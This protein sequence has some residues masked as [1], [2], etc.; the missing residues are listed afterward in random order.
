MICSICGD[1]EAVVFMRHSAKATRG[2]LALCEECAAL[3]GLTVGKG[4]LELRFEDLLAEVPPN[5]S[6]P[7]ARCPH[8]GSDLDLVRREARI[9]CP[10]CA[11]VFRPE[12]ERYMRT[13]SRPPYHRVSPEPLPPSMEGPRPELLS[14]LGRALAEEDYEAAA[15]IRDGLAQIAHPGQ[16]SPGPSGT[17]GL[18][19][20]ALGREVR[21]E[22]LLSILAP[23]IPQ[24]PQAAPPP[25]EA[26][27]ADVILDTRALRSRN[28]SGELFP[29]RAGQGGPLSQG[30]A[31]RLEE[32]SASLPGYAL[33]EVCGLGREFMPALAELAL[34]PRRASLDSRTPLL[35][36]PARDSY[37]LFCQDSHIEA[38]TRLR[39]LA[40]TASLSLLRAA[41]E[42]FSSF[43]PFAF[44]EDFG[45]LAPRL[46]DCGTGLCL[47][48]LVHLPALA[49]EGLVEKALRGLLSRGL[50]VKGFYGSEEGSLGDLWLVG[51]EWAFGAS[52]Q[53][54]ASEF[55]S[56]LS[57][58]ARGERKA[59]AGLVRKKREEVLDRAGRA[60]GLFSSCRFLGAAEAAENL[61]ALRLAALE[62][63]LSGIDPARLGMLVGCLG[64][65]FLEYLATLNPLAPAEALPGEAVKG[66]RRD[67]R[68]RAAWLAAATSGGAIA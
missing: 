34:L 42:A 61:S 37:L 20:A 48:S 26:P 63:E 13:R 46:Q 64:P 66:R 6:S 50:Q 24:R 9:G 54:I 41:T 56:A 38:R 43:G 51:T 57:A 2:E 19:G 68:L 47:E 31:T 7:V 10:A 49:Q 45:F 27:E 18:C 35:L 60:L 59:R 1:R 58:L 5:Q 39:G 17:D 32:F 23:T 28:F 53:D 33:V 12:I 3:R 30:L 4:R 52:E 8:C 21:G 62:G 55:E 22:G 15:L 65:A 36:A 25:G 11:E 44:D 67:E 14:R 40:A 29:G 16:A